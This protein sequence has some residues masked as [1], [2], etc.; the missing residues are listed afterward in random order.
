M[1][2]PPPPAALLSEFG[3]SSV[4]LASVIET[5]A[6]LR[7][8]T[9]EDTSEAMPRTAEGSRLVAEPLSRTAAVAGVWSW[10]KSWSSGSTS[11]TCAPETP[12]IWPMVEAIW[13]SS[14]RW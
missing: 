11:E 1:L 5:F 7:P 8:L 12:W 14:A 4:P 6:G 3:Q 2:T 13:P 9:D 10:E